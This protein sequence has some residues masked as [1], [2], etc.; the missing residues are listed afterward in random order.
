MNTN[1]RL[2]KRTVH[3]LATIALAGV[4]LAAGRLAGLGPAA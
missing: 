2:P 3:L 1:E 4:A